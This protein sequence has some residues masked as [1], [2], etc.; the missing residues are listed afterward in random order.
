MT[1]GS[2]TFSWMS[3]KRVKLA[4]PRDY[5]GLLRTAQKALEWSD[6]ELGRQAGVS[7]TS[8]G[9]LW[10]GEASWDTLEKV[11]KALELP[12]PDLVAPNSDAAQIERIRRLDPKRY[13]LLR[14][15]LAEPLPSRDRH[16]DR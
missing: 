9:R 14:Q 3:R 11:A 8:V 12:L 7:V 6:R 4:V 2:G 15:L 10:K 13:A 1:A 16:D 5:V